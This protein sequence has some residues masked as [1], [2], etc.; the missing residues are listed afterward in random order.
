LNAD[1]LES[2]DDWV[3]TFEPFWGHQLDRVKER[4]ERRAN[5]RAAG[6]DQPEKED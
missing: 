5:E 2:I 6:T 4:A 1:R 3:R